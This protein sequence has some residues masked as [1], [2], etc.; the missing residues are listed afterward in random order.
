MEILK[1]FEVNNFFNLDN[2]SFQEVF[3][4]QKKVWTALRTLPVYLESKVPKKKIAKKIK[5]HSS[6]ILLGKNIRIDSG[7]IIDP[8]VFLDASS[9]PIWIGENTRLL[10]GTYL[11]GPIIIGRK[12]QVRGEIKH[13]LILDGA[14]SDH[15]PNYIGDSI[16]GKNCRL[17]C[18]TVL[19]NRRFDRSEIKIKFGKKQI[20]TG[21][22]RFGAI[23][24]DE[25]RTGCNSVIGPGAII[26]PKTWIGPLLNIK[27]ECLGKNQLVKAEFKRR[28]VSKKAR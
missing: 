18:G 14:H 26:G 10:T 3:V 4:P 24:G 23:L 1:K 13:S 5:I 25:V 16:V 9:G 19:S 7:V 12:C 20:T 11:R 27:N 8:F 28:I 22:H 6:V 2:L 21:L 15:S 17:G